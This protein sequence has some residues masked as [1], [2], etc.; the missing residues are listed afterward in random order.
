MGLMFVKRPQHPCLTI[1]NFLTDLKRRNPEPSSGFSIVTTS[2]E[3]FQ[4][5]SWY[6]IDQAPQTRGPR[7]ACGPRDGSMRPSSN[8]WK[9]QE[10]MIFWFLNNIFVR[11]ST[12]SWSLLLF[13]N[14]KGIFDQQFVKVITIDWTRPFFKIYAARWTPFLGLMR[15]AGSYTTPMWP[16]SQFEFET[17]DIDITYCIHFFKDP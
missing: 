12:K 9:T 6:N 11:L 1:H 5:S 15:P 2:G 16:S 3:I 10:T 8:F 13:N 4:V 17:P 14:F 7:A